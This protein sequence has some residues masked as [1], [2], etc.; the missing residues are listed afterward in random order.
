MIFP[1]GKSHTH[2]T[3]LLPPAELW[4]GNVGHA[5]PAVLPAPHL[6]CQHC[7]AARSGRKPGCAPSSSDPLT[8]H[9]H[10]DPRSSA[11]KHS[12]RDPTWVQGSSRVLQPCT[13]AQQALRSQHRCSTPL[14]IPGNIGG[15][16]SCRPQKGALP[17]GLWHKPPPSFISQTYSAAG[18]GGRSGCGWE[19]HPEEAG[20]HQCNEFVSE[21]K[22]KRK[23]IFRNHQANRFWIEKKWNKCTDNS[24]RGKHLS[25]LSFSLICLALF[26]VSTPANSTR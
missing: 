14:W 20:D 6:H 25:N 13:W 9:I 17:D 19:T 18:S 10:T 23:I 11:L 12:E 5:A 2:A 21:T 16:G 1:S 8:L 15:E 7:W 26:S 22:H 4:H 24:A 3:Q